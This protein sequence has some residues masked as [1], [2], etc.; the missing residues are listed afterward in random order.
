MFLNKKL[1]FF[2]MVFILS[3]LSYAQVCEVAKVKDVLRKNLY[4]Y[5]TSA[6]P[7]PLALNQVKD[8]LI[9]YL[10]IPQ[11][12][13]TVDCSAPGSI[14]NTP[15]SNIVSTGESAPN[16][17]LACPDE[18]KYGECSSSKPKYCYGG[19][20]ISKCSFCGCPIGNSC[21][22]NGNC[23]PTASNITCFTNRDCGNSQFTGNYYCSNSYITKN[24]VNYTC[25]NP[26]TSSSNCVVSTYPITLSYCNSA[27]NQ[28]CINGYDICQISV[29]NQ[30]IACSDG[31]QNNQCSATKPLYCLNGTLINNCSVCGCSGNQTCSVTETCVQPNSCTDS[32]SGIAPYVL[33]YAYGIQN[34][35]FVN[36]SDTC[37]TNTTV[38]ERF[39]SGTNISLNSVACS[40]QCLNGACINQTN[41]NP[42]AILKISPNFGINGSFYFNGTASYDPDGVIMNYLWNFDDGTTATFSAG[43]HNY[44]LSRS[45]L[46]NLT[47][48]DN[49]GL[50]NSALQLINVT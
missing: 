13:V 48:F 46:I 1:I 47:V 37:Q 20:L 32:D 19:S 36:Q 7:S 26:G 31:T 15:I 50:L 35:S 39:C 33:G 44:N 49:G 21:D 11:G 14:S 9:F 12:S 34:S 2:V 28:S 38:Y 22:T 18:T 16:I 41:Q 25:I 24:Y 30:T 27:L 45:Y 29:I 42:V 10:N 23:N 8:I 5:L 4:L 43:I 40:Y 3:S 6:S 17:A